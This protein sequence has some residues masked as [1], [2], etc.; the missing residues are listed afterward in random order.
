MNPGENAEGLA[1]R[2]IEEFDLALANEERVQT[3]QDAEPTVLEQEQRDEEVEQTPG[4][5]GR[6][7]IFITP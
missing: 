2:E 7:H 3:A 1:G 4:H 6:W 5:S